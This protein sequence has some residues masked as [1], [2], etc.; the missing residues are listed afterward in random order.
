MPSGTQLTYI[1]TGG[2]E[3]DSGRELIPNQRNVTGGWCLIQ[4][5]Q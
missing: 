2:D 1:A 3:L 5:D 4:A